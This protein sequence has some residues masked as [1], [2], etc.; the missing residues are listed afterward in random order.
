VR[1]RFSRS[2][3]KWELFNSRNDTTPMPSAERRRTE[4]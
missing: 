4:G 3:S 2:E 1:L